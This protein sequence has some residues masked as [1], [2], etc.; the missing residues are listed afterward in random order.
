MKNT[1]Y[2]RIVIKAADYNKR[3]NSV[4]IRTDHGSIFAPKSQCIIE[5]ASAP[6]TYEEPRMVL[7]VP[8][9]V[10]WNKGTNAVYAHGFMRD[11][12]CTEAVYKICRQIEDTLRAANA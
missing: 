9:W 11:Y 3:E 6:M 1:T 7:L 8:D 12:Y 2:A 5:C 4:E 10:F